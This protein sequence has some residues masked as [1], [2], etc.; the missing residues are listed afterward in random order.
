MPFDLVLLIR[1]PCSAASTFFDDAICYL[2]VTIALVALSSNRTSVSSE[3]EATQRSVTANRGKRGGRT[4]PRRFGQ[5]GADLWAFLFMVSARF[6]SAFANLPR[7]AY[8]TM[9]CTASQLAAMG[10]FWMCG[11]HVVIEPDDDRK[12]ASARA[13]SPEWYKGTVAGTGPFRTIGADPLADPGG[14]LLPVHVTARA[15][16]LALILASQRKTEAIEDLL[17]QQG[18]REPVADDDFTVV[19]KKVLNSSCNVPRNGQLI[20][21]DVSFTSRGLA[22]EELPGTRLVP[23]LLPC[24]ALSK[25]IADG[26]K[27]LGGAPLWRHVIVV[28]NRELLFTIFRLTSL[29]QSGLC[30]WP[31]VGAERCCA[32]QELGCWL[33]NQPAP[34][35][36]DLQVLRRKVSH[37]PQLGRPLYDIY[38]ETWGDVAKDRYRFSWIAS[39]VHEVLGAL[40]SLFH[41]IC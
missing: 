14:L 3:T 13:L 34:L 2:G 17:C 40:L 4:R 33:R 5:V 29:G 24:N 20:P 26:S 18:T 1:A 15:A 22:S 19:G 10:H 8:S 39:S 11:H 27:P 28:S 25:T 21:L 16:A 31:G 37:F 12:G 35:L 41:S 9:R 6:L 36:H 38:S 32:G 23:H 7:E 30:W